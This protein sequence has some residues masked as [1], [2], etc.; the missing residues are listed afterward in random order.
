[1]ARSA[2]SDRWTNR[3][4]APKPP[5]TRT[6]L[7]TSPSAITSAGPPGTMRRSSTSLPAGG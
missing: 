1:M 7:S 4:C 2:S 3:T 6:T 5:R